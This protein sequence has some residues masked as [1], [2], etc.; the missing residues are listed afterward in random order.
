MGLL[1]APQ[2]ITLVVDIHGDNLPGIFIH[3]EGAALV[4][5]AGASLERRIDNPDPVQFVAR[6]ILIDVS[7]LNDVVVVV[8]VRMNL[9]AVIRRVDF[10]LADQLPIIAIHRTVVPGLS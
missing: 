10:C 7:A 5:V 6:Q 9:V 2:F 1:N 4:D 8:L 3:V